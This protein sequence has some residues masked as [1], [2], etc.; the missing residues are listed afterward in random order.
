MKTI[1]QE[2]FL[3]ERIIS[4][5]IKQATELHQLKMQLHEALQTLNPFSIIKS[6]LLEKDNSPDLKHLVI[7]GVVNLTSTYLAK[8]PFLRILQ[9]PIKKFLGNFVNTIS[10]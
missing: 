10:N 9:Q 4:L 2:Q 1:N 7:N 6:S 3:M 5:Q 8:N